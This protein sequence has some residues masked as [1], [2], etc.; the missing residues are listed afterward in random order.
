MGCKIDGFKTDTDRQRRNPYSSAIEL[1][2]G[3]LEP[4]PFFSKETVCRHNAGVKDQF[5]EDRGPMSQLLLCL[6]DLKPGC[7][8]LNDKGTDAFP[9]S[10]SRVS[11]RPGDRDAS[12]LTTRDQ[13]FC[14]IQDVRVVPAH[15]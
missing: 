2:H 6:S 3:N 4:F 7:A 8:F 12:S 15:L 10:G 14:P 9:F 1:H 11:H 13:G 5:I